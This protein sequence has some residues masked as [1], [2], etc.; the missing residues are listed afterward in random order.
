MR[1]SER[2]RRRRVALAAGAVALIVAAG[3]V[4]ILTTRDNSTFNEIAIQPRPDSQA[5][6]EA[7]ATAELVQTVANGGQLLVTEIGTDTT[8][9]PAID[10]ELSCPSGTNRL[11]CQQTITQATS[12]AASV[13]R[14]LVNSP[15]PD[16]LDFYSIFE[17][18]AGYLSEQP[19]HYQR[20]N[21]WI[22]TTGG[23]VVP[24]NLTRV[25]TGSDI[26]ALAHEAVAAGVFPGQHGCEGYQV[27]MVV[28]PN[29]PPAH[30]QALRDLLTV[31]IKGC[32][33]TLASWTS[34][35]IAPNPNAI[36]LPDIPGATVTPNHA[37]VH[38]TLSDKLD[39]F[40]VN[41]AAL[42]ATADAA[43]RDI[44]ADIEVRAPGQ[45][46]TCIG[47][48]DGTGTAAFDLALSRLRAITVCNQLRDQGIDRRLLH[49]VGAG[50]AT[51]SAADPSLRRVIITTGNRQ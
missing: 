9:A 14:R 50:K 42:T 48:T 46:I 34:R 18:T 5:T 8:A 35:W 51:P 36:A 44:A 4:H 21:L 3:L 27:H 45:P 10:V 29:G 13:I 49:P 31:L 40:A 25:T 37:G 22:N 7:D 32:G 47:S 11:I 38:Y 15:V 26:S 17:Q 16:R 24:A 43:L 23:Q 2:R 12:T 20:I 28:P 33:G 30:Q 41:S 39:D 1:P 6:V 19:T